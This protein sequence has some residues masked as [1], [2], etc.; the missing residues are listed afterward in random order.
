MTRP[1]GKRARDY[2]AEYARRQELARKRGFRSYA[3][4]R[5]AIETGVAPA[6]SPSRIRTKRTMDA[7]QNY[8]LKNFD[9]LGYRLEMAKG[10]SRMKVY[11][12]RLKF[13]EKRAKHDPH[14]LNLYI[15]SV[16]TAPYSA[17]MGTRRLVPSDKLR[18]L[19][20]DVLG[21][22]TIDEYE[23]RYGQGWPHGGNYNRWVKARRHTGKARTKKR[24]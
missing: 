23:A 22:T 4:Q 15:E 16:V 5:R 2:A 14:Y 6:I 24:R 21:I 12:E 3:A 18:H 9:V 17:T 19:L 11:D 20:V 13:D 8:M 10:F 7:Q 1:K